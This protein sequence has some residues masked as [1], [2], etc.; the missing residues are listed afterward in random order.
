MCSSDLKNKDK[1]KGPQAVAFIPK[2]AVRSDAN[3]SFVLLVRDGK[4]ER[5]T[6][7]LGLD[8]GTE[9]A[10]LSGVA[11]GDSLVV[12]GPEGLHDGDK[13]EIR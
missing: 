2:S 12:K 1:E 4:V 7:S 8:R 13:V 10:V 6:V 9:V 3:V 11:P 5:R